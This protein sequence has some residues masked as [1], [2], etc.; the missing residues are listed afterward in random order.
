MMT[1][2][3]LV[4]VIALGSLF[5]WVGCI[6][7]DERISNYEPDEQQETELASYD[8]PVYDQELDPT[9]DL[10]QWNQETR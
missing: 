6:V 2:L 1:L 9:T 10:G 5:L 3:V 7:T 4:I 8:N